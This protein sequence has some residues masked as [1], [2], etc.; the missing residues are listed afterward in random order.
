[1]DANKIGKTIY[2]LRKMHNYTQQELA[3]IIHVS[4]KAVSKWETGSSIPDIQQLESLVNLFKIS[5]DD[6][7]NGKITKITKLLENKTKASKSKVLSKF[8][9]TEWY[10]LDNAAKIYPPQA[11]KD[12]NM[13]FRI[14][15]VAKEKIDVLTLQTALEDMVDRF[16]TFMVTLRKGIFWYYF[17]RV[18][19]KP[20]VTVGNITP[21]QMIELNG[22]NYLFKV[23]VDNN[24]VA[25]DFF[26]SITDGNGGTVFLTS[27][28]TRYYE[29]KYGS[30]KSFNGAL[31]ILDRVNESEIEDSFSKYAKKDDYAKR[32]IV[33]AFHLEGEKIDSPI[34]T[35]LIMDSNK[36]NMIAK[37][38]D[39]TITEYLTTILL[40]ALQKQRLQMGNKKP[41]M[42]QVP[43]NLRKKFPSSTLR[44][45][46]YF[47]NIELEDDLLDFEIILNRVKAQLFNSI[48]KEEIQKP[49]NAN[50]RDERNFLRI[51]PLFLKRIALSIVSKVLGGDSTTISFS[52]IGKVSAPKELEQFIDRYEFVLKEPKDPGNCLSAISFNNKCTITFTRSMSSSQ[53]EKD[54]VDLI[55][56]ED[57][58]IIA[59]TNI[60]EV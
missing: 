8:N 52:N 59:E 22:N 33:K 21:C 35:H 14:S 57:I 16:P 28:L 23:S 31:N 29:L 58:N 13:V 47:V 17:D 40:M 37:S 32:D 19:K 30:V 36:L 1:M 60:K 5:Y 41:I 12:W 15:A 53:L 11:S 56:K 34:F 49:I 24:R 38:Y 25:V 6:L 51:F 48:K 27:L 43:V 4:D 46:V 39:A 42:V 3:D 10:K 2:K 45:F 18:S 20:M 55:S 50:V 44:N 54:F 7:I 9:P 26:H